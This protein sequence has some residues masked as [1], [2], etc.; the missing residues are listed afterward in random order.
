M[1]VAAPADKRFR[2]AH[3]KPVR[4]RRRRASAWRA[5]QGALLL[6]ALG[7]A[8]HRAV[9]LVN[10]AA[11]LHVTRIAVAGNDRLATGE[12]MA[13]LEGLRGRHILTTDL[14]A[15]RARVLTSSWVRD[16]TLRR[17][18]PS[19]VEVTITERRPLGI[20]RIGDLLYLIDSKG[21]IIDEYGP[22][23]GDLDLPI[24]SGLVS[25]DTPGAAATNAERAA[26]AARVLAA[27]ARRDIAERVSEL[28]V[29]DPFNAAVLLQ[30][31]SAVIKLGRED[32]FERLQSYLELESA[33]RDRVPE[34]DYVDLRFG[35][36][37]YVRAVDA[38]AVR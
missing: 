34:I 9:R 26:L 11:L 5:L 17:I 30:G 29:S 33:L 16:A 21:V 37:V 24:V 27:L 35:Q 18:V 31:D 38:K 15:W 28:D 36:R 8:G 19:T 2:R 22:V 20:G 3:V 12:V 23:H 13:L 7:Y 6:V 25:A 1:S 4:K 32:F 10:D 14:T